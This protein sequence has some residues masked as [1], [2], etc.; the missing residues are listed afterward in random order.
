M[1]LTVSV[2]IPAY[3][4]APYLPAAIDSVL[5]QTRPAQEI[6]VIDDGSQD[7]TAA[8]AAG[9]APQVRLISQPNRGVAEAINHGV[10]LASGDWLAFCDADDLWLPEKLALQTAALAADPQ[11]GL[12]FGLLEQFISPELPPAA[13]ARLVCPPEPAPGLH[14]GCMLARRAVFTA[15]GPF[16]AAWRVGM[17]IDWYART[18]EAQIPSRILPQVIYRRRLHTTNVMLRLKH[19]RSEFAHILKAALDR[20]RAETP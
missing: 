3:N 16:S 10:S 12:V 2:I 19:E 15:V 11:L 5:A 14:L 20:R 18:R 9:Y 8:L 6:L 13:A 1:N 7:D 4:A 17:F